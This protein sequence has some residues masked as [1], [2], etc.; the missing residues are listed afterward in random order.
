MFGVAASLL[1]SSREI[2][3]PSMKPVL[4]SSLSFSL[5]KSAITFAGATASSEETAIAVGP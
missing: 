4:I 1:T 2:T 3:A 5:A